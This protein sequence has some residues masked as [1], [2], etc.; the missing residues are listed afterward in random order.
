M[1]GATIKIAKDFLN[2]LTKASTTYKIV[3]FPVCVTCEVSR[4]E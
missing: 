1:H 4:E 3:I 2:S